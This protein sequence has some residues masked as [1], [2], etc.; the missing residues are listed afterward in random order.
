MAEPLVREAFSGLLRVVTYLQNMEHMVIFAIFRA[1]LIL[2]C[3]SLSFAYLVN[4]GLFLTMDFSFLKPSSRK[5]AYFVP[6]YFRK[7]C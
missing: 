2:G 7:H 6:A 1:L 4:H 5:V 3:S